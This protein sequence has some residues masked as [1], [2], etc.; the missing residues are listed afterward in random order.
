EPQSIQITRFLERFKNIKKSIYQD[1]QNVH[2][3]NV[4]N[5]VTESVQN[6]LRDPKPIP[7]LEFILCSDLSADIKQAITEYY[8]DNTIHSVQ[9]ITYGELMDYVWNR[10]IIS[11]HKT[12]LMKILEEQI[13]DAD[14]KCFTGRF[15][16]TLS[17]L[18]GFYPDINIKIS[19]NSQIAA[20][21]LHF[22][23]KIGDIELLKETVIKELIEKGY[24]GKN[25]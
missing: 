20:T 4:Q 3:P 22:K 8:A 25:Q 7:A 21:I 6:L 16:R 11:E 15:N 1:G 14:C 10:I 17:I 2:D 5:S 18:E 23:E 12:E 19:D 9:L 13:R 24:H